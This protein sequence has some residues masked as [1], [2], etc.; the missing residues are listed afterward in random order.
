MNINPEKFKRLALIFAKL[1]NDYQNELMQQAYIL[2]LKQSQKNQIQKEKKIFKSEDEFKGEIE[3]RSN[4]RAKEVMDML[5]LFEKVGDSEKAQLLVLID[6]LSGGKMTQ[7]TEIEIKI[8][9]QKVAVKDYIADILPGVDFIQV[10]NKVNG[11][12]KEIDEDKK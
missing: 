10:N 6:R 2:E 9:Q 11:Y 7:K 4:K 8:N 1:D 3:H 5:E 12:L